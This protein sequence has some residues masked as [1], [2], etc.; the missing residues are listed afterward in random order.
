MVGKISGT[1]FNS[2]YTNS[3]VSIPISNIEGN[4]ESLGS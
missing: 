4:I 1:I 2:K 3:A